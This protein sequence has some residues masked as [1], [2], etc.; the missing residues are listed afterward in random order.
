MVSSPGGLPEVGASKLPSGGMQVRRPRLCDRID[1]LLADA[2]SG[3]GAAILV[4]GE[5]GIGKTALL[6]YAL[7]NGGDAQ[8]LSTRGVASEAVLAYSGLA[9]VLRPLLGL[10][11][12]LPAPQAA[13][14]SSALAIGPP[15]G[16]ERFAVC[17]GTLGLLEAAAARAPVVVGVDDLPWLD[18]ASAEA[19]L[20]TARR[21]GNHRILLLFTSRLE[22]SSAEPPPG[23]PVLD[24]PGFDEAEAAELLAAHGARVGSAVPRLVRATGGNPL[25]LLDLPRLLDTAEL[26]S[27]PA[28]DG[29]APVGALLAS[30][31][32]SHVA[33]L[34]KQT[35]RALLVVA[36]LDGAET[37]VVQAALDAAGHAVA[38]LVAAEDAGLLRVT[39][40]AVTFRHPLVRSAV[41][42]QAP[43]GQLR[44]IHR[45]AA[46]GLTV[47]AHPLDREAQ[48]WHLAQSVIGLDDE[49]ADQLA[50]AAAAAVARGGLSWGA[51]AYERAA[52]HTTDADRRVE[53]L[54]AGASAACLA[55]LLDRGSELL[56][57]AVDALGHPTPEPFAITYTR[58][59]LDCAQGR[60]TLGALRLERAAASARDPAPAQAAGLFVNATVAAVQA[61]EVNRA[62]ASATEAV[63]IFRALGAES[64]PVSAML[65]TVQTLHGD[66]TEA[67]PAL[68]AARAEMEAPH[69][70]GTD[71]S[72]LAY[73]GA[74]YAVADDLE[75]AQKIF[76]RVVADARYAGAL[77]L[78]PAALAWAA[79]VEIERGN[80][81]AA[82]TAAAEATSLAVETGRTADLPQALVVLSFLDACQGRPGARS[83]A[84][85][86][87]AAADAREV[88]IVEVQ[89]HHTLGLLELGDGRRGH[90]LV[91]FQRC[92][93]LAR[94][95]GLGELGFVPWA[96][97][98]V[99][100]LANTGSAAQ[101]APVV[102]TMV[103]HAERRNTPYLWALAERC[104]GLVAGRDDLDAS[105]RAA[106]RWHEKDAAHPFDAAQT[107]LCFGE[108][109]RRARRRREA[110]VELRAA[111]TTFTGL[112]AQ[113]WSARAASELSA[114]EGA[115]HE[116]DGSVADLLTA[117]EWR[118][119][120]AV[121][122]GASNPEVAE[123]LFLTRKTVEFH[124]SRVY[125]KLGIG[126]REELCATVQGKDHQPG[127]G[128]KPKD[129]PG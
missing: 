66:G 20:Y 39:P 23:V 38:D 8:V 43:T 115:R 30:V 27:L 100:C 87:V 83:R 103:A 111:W 29:P 85:E 63:E 80:W 16:N 75:S 113:P 56:R 14:L 77:G 99:E 42:Q 46:A 92:G 96:P 3:S 118:V 15:M 125:R 11:P 86:A 37:A 41:V 28:R 51:L 128:L 88:R 59:L 60:P 21:V 117:Q 1:A 58:S 33:A 31:Y 47:S 95:I 97:P 127:P 123:A 19:L 34:P 82:R 68:A 105:F 107:R 18:E 122:D 24:V 13:A 90:A 119:A 25:A 57:R 129:R 73:L 44:A 98:L 76:A 110:A 48:A 114:A 17:A 32:G 70:A 84:E 4:R 55:G 49:V 121:A 109:L 53:R 26:T 104:R 62:L 67:L 120:R 72:N 93:D 35:R 10:L 112:G 61:G 7:A 71:L 102:A 89:G 108:R 50:G 64:A 54:L 79:L 22:P 5:P 81:D 36:L 91:H 65:A 124:L 40:G 45:A 69:L 12:D 6:E 106:L 94:A 116:S 9:P 52:G 78:L 101:A 2:R 74:S 126:S